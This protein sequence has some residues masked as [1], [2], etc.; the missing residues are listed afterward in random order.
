MMN[1]RRI[2]FFGELKTENFSSKN[3][4]VLMG[5]KPKDEVL[6]DICHL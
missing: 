1:S 6:A 4:S 2:N 5:F 3:V